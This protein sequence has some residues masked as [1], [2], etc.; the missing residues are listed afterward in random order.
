VVLGGWD[1]E[2]RPR[3]EA[4]V[5]QV[6]EEPEIIKWGRASMP[7][8]GFHHNSYISQHDRITALQVRYP[9]STTL[10]HIPIR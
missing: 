8:G 3:T 9:L 10:I 4:W 7:P 1:A 6:D 5:M 2:S